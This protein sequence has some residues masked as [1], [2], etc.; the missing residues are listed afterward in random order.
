[1]ENL[2]PESFKNRVKESVAKFG[3]EVPVVLGRT[4][5]IDVAVSIYR[6]NYF[7][8]YKV[9]DEIVVPFYMTETPPVKEADKVTE[10]RYP[11]GEIVPS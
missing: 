3:Y 7:D 5:L 8:A 2:T 10:F 4:A 6:P 11:F 1:M 9:G